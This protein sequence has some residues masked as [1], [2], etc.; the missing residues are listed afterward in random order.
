MN[1]IVPLTADDS[2][3]VPLVADDSHVVPLVADD[4]HVIPMTAESEVVPLRPERPRDDL[5]PRRDWQPS[6][7]T[8]R[9]VSWMQ[10]RM[11]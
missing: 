9:G 10:E 5:F 7:W 3:V 4:S 8:E 6:P 1:R 2:H 11:A